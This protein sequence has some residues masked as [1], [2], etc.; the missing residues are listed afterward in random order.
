MDRLEP[1]VATPPD[2]TAKVNELVDAY[3][4]L[5]EG[6]PR[7]M[8]RRVERQ[9]PVPIKPEPIPPEPEE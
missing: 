6:L 3:N 1:E 4:G 7:G 2:L 8:Q 9:R 5:I